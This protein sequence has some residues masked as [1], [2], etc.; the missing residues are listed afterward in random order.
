[1]AS[2][3]KSPVGAALMR[4]WRIHTPPDFIRN[5][6]TINGKPAQISRRGRI[7]AALAYSY[8]T[9]FYT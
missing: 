3:R 8:T 9:G 6:G 5:Q 2:L 1:M 7:D 4:P